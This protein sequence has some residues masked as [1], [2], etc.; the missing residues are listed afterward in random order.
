MKE[1]YLP[2]FCT[3]CYRSARTGTNF[4]PLP[5]HGIIKNFCIPNGLLT[6]EEY[7]QDH[8][9]ERVKELAEKEIK[10]RYL[11][12]CQEHL[13]ENAYRKLVEMLKEI[14]EGERDLH[15]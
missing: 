7:L 14:Q 1:G 15:F 10:P 6:L 11:R 4:M 13:P 8:A 12:W 5:K 3:A 2:S 9:S